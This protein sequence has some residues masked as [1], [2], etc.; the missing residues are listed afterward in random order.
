MPRK[1]KSAKPKS[2]KPKSKHEIKKTKPKAN[3][4]KVIIDAKEG[5]NVL[6]S[7]A[8]KILTEPVCASPGCKQYK[9]RLMNG[10]LDNY[11]SDVCRFKHHLF[12]RQGALKKIKAG[13]NEYDVDP[14]CDANKIYEYLN[15]CERTHE[16]RP[17]QI[18][19][20][21]V[22][23]HSDPELPSIAGLA[24]YCGVTKE[25]IQRYALRNRDYREALTV[26]SHMQEQYLVK[27]GVS[28]RYNNKITAIL[29]TTKHGYVDKSI[30]DNDVRAAG[31]IREI[32]KISDEMA[33][34]FDPMRN[35]NMPMIVTREADQN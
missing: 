32:Y 23:L 30:R 28:G 10:A 21:K 33:G 31:I 14:F 27:Y 4:G 17:F 3:N 22:I 29:L 6:P 18:A 12:I 25:R 2:A 26:L 24:M 11:C 15:W 1:A 9:R 8:V 16:L 34:D 35:E 19:P 7:T 5:E 13:Q 20:D